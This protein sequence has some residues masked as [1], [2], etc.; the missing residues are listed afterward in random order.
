V[1]PP[2][3]AN[4]EKISLSGRVRLVLYQRFAFMSASGCQDSVAGSNALVRV[5]Y[6]LPP[7]ATIRPS[8]SVE[9]PAQNMSWN[10]LSTAWNEPVSG[11]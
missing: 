3:L 2:A 5:S 11:S 1:L 9:T 10:P 4:V 7:D 8:S 6:G